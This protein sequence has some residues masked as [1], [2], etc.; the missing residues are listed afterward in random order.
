VFTFHARLSSD[1]GFGLKLMYLDALSDI[2][3]LRNGEGKRQNALRVDTEPNAL[4]GPFLKAWFISRINRVDVT[5]I[6]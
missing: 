6:S 5:F 4:G 2:L 1:F 3:P